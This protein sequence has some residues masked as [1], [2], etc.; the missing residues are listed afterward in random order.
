MALMAEYRSLIVYG[1]I[2]ILGLVYFI[3]Q[4]WY[5]MHQ[6]NNSAVKLHFT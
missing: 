5:Q 6:A 4:F 2:F 3:Y 1:V